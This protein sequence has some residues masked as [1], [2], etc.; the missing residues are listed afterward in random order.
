MNRQIL[1]LLAHLSSPYRYIRL[2]ED[3]QLKVFIKSDI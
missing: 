1:H 3:P 2:K